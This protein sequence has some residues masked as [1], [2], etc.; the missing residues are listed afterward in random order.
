MRD[1]TIYK[2]ILEFL[3]KEYGVSSVTE[4]VDEGVKGTIYVDG[5]EDNLAGYTITIEM[6][7]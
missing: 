2:S 1:E 7:T 6:N 4:S 3:K 5:S